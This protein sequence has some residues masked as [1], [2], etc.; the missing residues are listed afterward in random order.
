MGDLLMDYFRRD[1][2]DKELEQLDA[3]LKGPEE[4]AMQF[5]KHAELFYRGLGLP[6][7]PSTP[8][9]QWLKLG[10]AVAVGAWIAWQLARPK[11]APVQPLI[12]LPAPAS[13]TTAARPQPKRA[14][15]PSAE[16]DR[17]SIETDL[18]DQRLVTVRV[19]DAGSREIRV[20]FA[21][22]LE[23]GRRTF[24]W[25][26]KADGRPVAPGTYKIEVRSGDVIET[27]AVQINAAP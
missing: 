25:D 11:P 27:K 23:P 13:P 15:K 2:T 22:V 21:G 16:Y 12:V 8:W 9:R 5:A 3:L 18:Q 7:G 17:L 1:L 20:L 24:D 14:P 26:G 6:E 10:A 4:N 19:L